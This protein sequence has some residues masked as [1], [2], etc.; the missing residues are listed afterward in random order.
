M[1]K[2]FQ[3]LSNNEEAMKVLENCVYQGLDDK[4]IQQRLF[5]EVGYEWSI[6]SIRRNRIKIGV[7]KDP[8]TI[9]E[10]KTRQMELSGPPYGLTETEKANWFRDNFKKTNMFVK[11]CEYLNENEINTYL[12]DYGQLCC[13][14]ED[15]VFSEFFQIDDFL[16]HRILIERQF[17]LMQ[18][19]QTDIEILN[20]WIL[21]NKQ[22]PDET[23]EK[24]TE[25]ISANNLLKIKYKELK[26]SNE[27][28][29]K[30]AAERQK[31][32]SNLSATRKDRIE[33][34][35][36]GKE[37]FFNLVASIQQ[38]QEQRDKHG[39]YAELT[40]MSSEE[41]QKELRS[42]IEF[43]DGEI[44]SVISDHET[45]EIQDNGE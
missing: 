7:K 25:R 30:L 29:D 3:R 12:E 36:G 19:L 43:P 1:N 33:Q 22:E 31:I 11:I 23:K 39:R 13:Q 4:K 34:L 38:S 6:D 40:K 9:K 27:R 35:T 24:K 10:L 18:H 42:P 5:Q 21:N 14:F 32:Q 16:K 17:V 15:I 45:K 41:I 2:K 20:V 28:Y 37:S 26:E 8:D 44:D